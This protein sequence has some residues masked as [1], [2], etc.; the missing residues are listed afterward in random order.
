V[1]HSNRPA[2]QIDVAVRR[3]SVA[4]AEP[5]AAVERPEVRVVGVVLLHV[6]D[7]VLDLGEQVGPLG[8]PGIRSVAGLAETGWT[9][10]SVV[11]P[12]GSAPGEHEAGRG[13]EAEEELS[14]PEVVSH[15]RVTLSLSG[16]ARQSVTVA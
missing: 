6:D 4:D 3:D 2:F 13:A 14:P 11:K 15:A 5:V 8:P 9:T 12:P 10:V 16:V 7:D 1:L